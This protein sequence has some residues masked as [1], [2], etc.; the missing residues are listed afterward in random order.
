MLL[1]RNSSLA[2][3]LVTF[4]HTVFI[5][6]LIFSGYIILASDQMVI[7][8]VVLILLAAI[9]ART[10]GMLLNRVIDA[11][12]D[13]KNPRTSSRPIPSGRASKN[14]LVLFLILSFGIYFIS[15]WFLCWF[16]FL[17]SPIPIILFTIYPYTK[18][19][20]YLCHFFLGAT[21][22]LGPIAGGVAA[23][24]DLEGFYLSLP[25]AIF[26]FFWISG[27]DILYA[28][29]DF[30]HDISNNIFSVPSSFGIKPAII[31]SSFCFACSLGSLSYFFLFFR[32]NIL[33]IAL[34]S[35]IAI[36][37]IFQI[38]RSAKKDYSFFKYNSYIGFLI[39][40]LVISDILTT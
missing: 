32:S 15:C 3:E 12:I 24:C 2:L 9:S 21:L 25:I 40:I 38:I 36:N 39:L 20:T 4:S 18:R 33:S 13:L 5:L 10:I 16:V 23:G 29:Q 30:E 8:E 28:L 31:I 14:F 37:F 7:K 27:F 17:L 1:K 19:F 6:P 22:S 35:L 26:T 34:V 11:K